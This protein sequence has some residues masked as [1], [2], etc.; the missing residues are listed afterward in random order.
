M[1]EVN[2]GAFSG[3]RNL[4]SINLPEVLY[5][6]NEAFEFSG[7]TELD[8]PKVKEIYNYAFRET[9]LSRITCPS[10]EYIGNNAFD[11]TPLRS[12][13]APT[14]KSIGSGAFQYC[15]YLTNVVISDDCTVIPYNC[16]YCC[17]NLKTF[18]FPSALTK[19]ESSAFYGTSLTEAILPER[20][21]TIE[22]EALASTHLTKVSIPA[23][24]EQIDYSAFEN[25]HELAEIS[26]F[27]ITP[28]EY[29]GFGSSNSNSTLYV[30][31]M[32]VA[33]Y[34]LSEGWSHFQSVQPLDTTI[35]DIHIFSRFNLFN[36]AGIAENPNLTVTGEGHLTINSEKP[37]N[38]NKFIWY[39]NLFNGTYYHNQFD[40][41]TSVIAQSEM[42]VNDVE[43]HLSITPDTQLH[44][45][46][47]RC[48]G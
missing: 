36:T 32:S 38:W 20:V 13:E 10:L 25:T 26:C 47:I 41:C 18:K 22:N 9:R 3:T 14:A 1:T 2:D 8:L 6:G 35:E 31:A 30:P 16:F 5:I 28:T 40:R 42:T 45:L 44:F 7:L 48:K 23:S 11:Y 37:L 4:S 19:I 33:A 34:R 29:S 17:T 21:T 43:V 46:P 27:A 15:E 39:N 12:F 24:I